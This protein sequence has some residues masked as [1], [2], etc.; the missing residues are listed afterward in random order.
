MY[1][2]Y[3]YIY[4]VRHLKQGDS[5]QTHAHKGAQIKY[6]KL[7]TSLY[8]RTHILQYKYRV[9]SGR[10]IKGFDIVLIETKKCI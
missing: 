8:T 4:I 2:V 9:R 1:V 3:I 5:S 10:I 7:I 6:I